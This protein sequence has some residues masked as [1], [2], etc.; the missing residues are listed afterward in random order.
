M[1]KSDSGINF[2][3]DDIQTKLE[4]HPLRLIPQLLKQF[5]SI[6]WCSGTGGGISIRLGNEIYIAPSGVQK[7][8][9]KVICLNIN[10]PN[11]FLFLSLAF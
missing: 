8:R 4:E 5:Y 10:S 1:L 2:K 11:S 9:V 3:L 7:E 6:G